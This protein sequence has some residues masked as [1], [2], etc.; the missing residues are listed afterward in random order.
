MNK[1]VQISK[2]FAS[3]LRYC[4]DVAQR[5]STKLCT[6]F[7]CLLHWHIV[8]A[9]FW[10]GALAS[11]KIHFASNSCILL[12]WQ[13]YCTSLQQRPSAKVCGMVQGME[14]RNFRWG[15]HLYSAGRPSR[16]ASA[17]ILVGLYVVFHVEAYWTRMWADAQRNGRPTE[18]HP[19]RKF[20]N[21]I[22]CTTP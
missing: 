18:W 2:G 8:Y 21:S 19:Q 1:V 17:H 6:T 4:T 10:G 13:C 7:G 14:L 12:N 16:W 3:W 5:R 9:F 11:C 15:C 20:I 22:L